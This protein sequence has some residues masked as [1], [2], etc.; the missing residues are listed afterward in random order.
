A[1]CRDFGRPV[2]NDAGFERLQ[3]DDEARCRGNLLDAFERELEIVR[4][5][6]AERVERGGIKSGFYQPAREDRLHLRGEDKTSLEPS[7]IERLDSEPVAGGDHEPL[8]PI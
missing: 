6:V 8:G 3:V 1:V 7:Q 5:L 2:A 4:T